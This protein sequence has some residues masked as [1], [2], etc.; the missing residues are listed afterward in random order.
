LTSAPFS[1]GVSEDAAVTALNGR[2]GE[3]QLLAGT[4]VTI[5]PVAAGFVISATGAVSDNDWTVVGND[6]HSTP[7]GNVGIGQTSPASKLH[8]GGDATLGASGAPGSLFAYNSGTSLPSLFGGTYSNEGSQ[9]AIRDEEGN[10]YMGAQ[11]DI[12]D[13]GGFFW[14]QN[15]N[16]GSA[17]QIDGNYLG[18]GD[19]RITMFGSGSS[20]VFNLGE[21]EN[22][23]VQLPGSSVSAIEILDEPGLASLNAHGTSSYPVEDSYAVVTSRTIS[24][25]TDGF[26]LAMCS[27]EIDLR[28]EAT[29]SSYVTAGLSL[30]PNTVDNNQDLSYYLP[31]N[32]AN[33]I[34]L[35]PSTPTAVYPVSAGN[36]TVYLN[37]RKVGTSASY[38][39]DTQLNLVFI[40]TAYG[41]V[42]LAAGSDGGDQLNNSSQSPALTSGDIAAEQRASIQANDDRVARELAD[43]RAQIQALQ[44]EMSVRNGDPGVTAR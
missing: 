18:T 25:P 5:T 34:Y 14:V 32:A 3:I 24:A 10:T 37:A 15:G 41:S 40:P 33:G 17:F 6:M 8:V 16:F 22:G 43:L 2:T 31:A 39:W 13:T 11:P 35:V 9:M 44:Q 36:H 27:L 42:A 1:L 28:H 19:P 12:D 4:N 30:S 23:A 38:I 29:G 7:S 26:I 20:A 21:S